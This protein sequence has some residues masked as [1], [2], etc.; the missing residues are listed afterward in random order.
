MRDLIRSYKMILKRKPSVS[1]DSDG[2]SQPLMSSASSSS[3]SFGTI[4]EIG[5]FQHDSDSSS[6]EQ[7]TTEEKPSSINA[8]P[9]KS[10]LRRPFCYPSVHDS[11]V[12]DIY[13]ANEHILDR[14]QFFT[15]A[16]GCIVDNS[17]SPKSPMI[18]PYKNLDNIE[19]QPSRE[20]T[21]S[22]LVTIF[23]IWNT[24]MGT[25]ILAMS[26][27]LAKAGFIPGIILILF[28]SGICLYTAYIILQVNNRHGFG[29]NDVSD[30]CRSLI[31]PW[32][33][34]VA[35]IFS[36]I[37]LIGACIVYWILM[38]NFL[39]N[40]VHF[41]Y[42]YIDH[43]D[44]I[45]VKNDTVIC[46]KDL[47]ETSSSY[48]NTPNH[49]IFDNVWDLYTTVPIFL[50]FILFPLLNFKSPTFF[51]KF[52]SLGTI[53]VVY[54]LIFVSVK[55]YSW[56]VNINDWKADVF[57]IKSTFCALSGMLSLSYF[58][59]NII[60]SIVKNNKRQE[61]NARD[62]SIA[63]C[64]VTFT[65]LFIGCVFYISF[66]LA[67]SCIE[68][69]ILNN[70]EKYDKLSIIARMLLLFQLFTVFPL[71]AF[72]L[73]KDILNNLAAIFK[74]GRFGEFSY[75]KVI[76]LNLLVVIICI[77]FACFLPRIGT[78]IRYT[79]ALSGMVYIFTL[80]SLLKIFSLR[81]DNALTPFQLI[82]HIVIIIVGALNLVSQFFI[83]E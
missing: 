12:I 17:L 30:I 3:T 31:G 55:A 29:S 45:I 83:V 61:N 33:A 76:L 60:V 44:V 70:F 21:Q 5:M 42:G 13:T 49:V 80:P 6:Y 43:L 18:S 25:S 71:I 39:Y 52:N 57:T 20:T 46:P 56:G 81:K 54:L 78:L 77:L 67:K 79:G 72:M 62:L 22:S 74:N 26:W 35:K 14:Y 23:A 58:I 82:F 9:P 64:L 47:N 53:S 28:V 75:G 68:D 36:L 48:P 4:R 11:P 50:A 24:I 51:T 15:K 7:M 73:R 10:F 59:H 34:I 1:D 69:N 65:Y 2:E 16:S 41:I 66:P 63:Y 19:E 37:V 32:A 27:G 8:T 38:S 40:S